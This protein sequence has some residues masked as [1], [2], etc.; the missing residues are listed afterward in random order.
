MIE[1]SN[2]IAIRVILQQPSPVWKD[3]RI[4]DLKLY[5]TSE[6]RFS[7]EDLKLRSKS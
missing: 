3:F 1:L 7:I 4:E 6:V 5:R 2:V